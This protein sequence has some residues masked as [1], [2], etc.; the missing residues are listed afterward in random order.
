M[1][2]YTYDGMQGLAAFEELG[3]EGRDETD[4]Y[5]LWQTLKLSWNKGAIDSQLRRSELHPLYCIPP[6]FVLYFIVFGAN[7]FGTLLM[8]SHLSH[9]YSKFRFRAYTWTCPQY[10]IRLSVIIG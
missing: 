7:L 6:L 8:R 3:Y 2:T 4:G 1:D 9:P 5:V 10:S